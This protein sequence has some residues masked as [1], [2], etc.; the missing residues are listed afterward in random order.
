MRK[1][2]ALACLLMAC[3]ADNKKVIVIPPPTVTE[4][5]TPPS[6]TV[7]ERG[8][9]WSIEVLN[10]WEK[11]GITTIPTNSAGMQFVNKE[12]KIGLAVVREVLPTHISNEE[13]A[14]GFELY[15]KSKD[16]G[17]DDL[18]NV[19]L[20]DRSFILIEFHA[21]PHQFG[22]TIQVQAWMS[23][24]DKVTYTMICG[25]VITNQQTPELCNQMV[26]TFKVDNKDGIVQP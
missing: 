2:L 18:R 26:S 4:S 13:L 9:D 3:A 14:F 7:I 15:L 8:E 25:S 21:I 12:Q 24:E 11:V 1:L 10:G 16:I 22:E 6:M 5:P 23:A 19:K 17:I 20:N